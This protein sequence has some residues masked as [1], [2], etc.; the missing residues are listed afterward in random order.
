MGSSALK[1]WNA[2]FALAFVLPWPYYLIKT[3]LQHLIH[4]RIS[5]FD[6]WVGTATGSKSKFPPNFTRQRS[7]LKKEEVFSFS[8][9]R[10]IE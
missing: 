2:A 5:F 9:L 7:L 3:V 10:K 4:I 6:S 1:Y 8:D